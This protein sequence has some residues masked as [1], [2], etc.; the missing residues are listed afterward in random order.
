MPN[1]QDYGVDSPID[2]KPTLRFPTPTVQ[3]QGAPQLLQQGIAGLQHGEEQDAAMLG[4]IR[5]KA[6]ELAI[7]RAKQKAAHDDVWAKEGYRWDEATQGY[8]P[9]EEKLAA[10]DVEKKNS[11]VGFIK[12]TEG[13]RNTVFHGTLDNPSWEH[14]NPPNIYEGRGG[15][16]GGGTGTTKVA[17]WEVDLYTGT[18]AHNKLASALQLVGAAKVQGYDPSD[19]RA[20]ITTDYSKLSTEAQAAMEA[21]EKMLAIIQP[22]TPEFISTTRWF[23]RKATTESDPAAKQIYRA[24]SGYLSE[25][26]TG[27]GLVKQKV[28][29][30]QAENGATDQGQGTPTGTVIQIPGW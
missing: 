3:M 14:V 27:R 26:N 7:E 30:Y 5:A 20:I 6:V 10:L 1:P 15:G 28:E 23:A 18:P 22:G 12:G 29:K 9:T 21:G 24:Y 4:A 11:Q 2:F 25:W 16:G 17:K 19:G 13:S 8:T